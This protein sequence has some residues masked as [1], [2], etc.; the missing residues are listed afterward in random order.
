MSEAAPLSRR[1]TARIDRFLLGLL[2]E[3]VN[4]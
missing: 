2:Q 4:Q 3:T 1:S